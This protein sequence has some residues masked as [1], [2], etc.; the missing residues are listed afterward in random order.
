M[1]AGSDLPAGD[2]PRKDSKAAAPAVVPGPVACPQMSVPSCGHVV[3]TCMDF[4]FVEPLHHFLSADGLT[5]DVDVLAWPGGVACLE[6]QD[7][8]DR[9]AEALALA[10]HLHGCRHAILVT[11]E[12]CMRLG[13]SAVHGGS[14]A[15]GEVLDGYLRRAAERVRASSADMEVRLVRLTLD[16]G[17]IDVDP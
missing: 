13:G 8:A 2:Q 3:L 12:D 4:R 9:A 16:G 11:H 17:A 7:D 10:V 15:E 5:G 6:L 14:D 1:G